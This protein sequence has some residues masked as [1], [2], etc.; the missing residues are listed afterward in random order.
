MPRL[1]DRPVTVSVSACGLPECF[2]WRGR[3]YRVTRLLDLWR[4]TGRWWAG[5]RPRF[6]YRVAA[7]EKGVFELYREEGAPAWYLYKAY[8]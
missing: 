6:F 2:S 5:E 7:G 8:D 3:T 1:I 4:E